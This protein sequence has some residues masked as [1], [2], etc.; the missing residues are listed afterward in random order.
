M[1]LKTTSE[2]AALR[3]GARVMLLVPLLCLFSA[4]SSPPQ[5]TIVE[6]PVPTIFFP[7]QQVM[8]SGDYVGFMADN[9]HTLSSCG[10]GKGCE[11]ALFNLGF[12]HAYPKSPYFDPPKAV[13]YFDHLIEEYSDTPLSYQAMAWKALLKKSQTPQKGTS[14]LEDKIKSKE[15]TINELQERIQKSREIDEQMDRK[16]RELIR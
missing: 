8:R 14:K 7:P 4:C 16:E 9:E 11:Q 3:A 6:K 15:A 5:R 13:W 2:R 12:L 1:I 10:E